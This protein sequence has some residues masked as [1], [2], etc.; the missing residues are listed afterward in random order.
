MGFL[1]FLVDNRMFLLAGVLL[2]FTSSY[3]QTYFISIFAANIMQDFGLTNGQWGGI[4]TAGTTLSA[5]VMVQAGVLTDRFRVRGLS[6]FVAVGLALAC[7][8]MAVAP[9]AILLVGVIFALRFFG[10]GM[11]S[12]LAIVAMARWFVAARGRALSVASMGFNIGQ[13]VLPILFVALLAHFDWRLVWVFAAVMVVV[14][15][16]AFNIL[17]RQERS[18]RSMVSDSISLGM[19]DRQWTRGQAVRHPLFWLMMPALIGP[20]AWGTALFFQQVHLAE[21]KGWSLGQFV[22]LYPLYTF[23]TIAATFTA[24]AAIDRFGTWRIV[25]AYMIPYV[26]SFLI[27]GSFPTIGMAAVGLVVFALGSGMQATL[28]GAFWAEFYGT[29]HLGA[30]KAVAVAIMVFGSA[31]GPGVSGVLID[32]G[33]DFPVQMIGYAA[34]FLIAGVLATVGVLRYRRRR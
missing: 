33:V 24:G 34:Y 32:H 30:I 12:T 2:S 28:P 19:D 8:A 25:P 27:I 14:T 10:Q 11:M 15:I 9:G 5:L 18:P 23:A 22:A 4:Y 16:P 1:R 13:A 31:I 3:G 26:A 21:V 17:L 29:A 7:L 6:A 20:P